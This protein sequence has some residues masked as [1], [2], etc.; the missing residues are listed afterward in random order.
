MLYNYV[1]NYLILETTILENYPQR[2]HN[3]KNLPGTTSVTMMTLTPRSD[4]NQ[5]SSQETSQQDN[6][7]E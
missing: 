6:H 7:Q 3:N 4:Y 1:Q 2:N 5:Q